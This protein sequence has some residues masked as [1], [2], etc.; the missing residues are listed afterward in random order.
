MHRYTREPHSTYPDVVESI[1]QTLMFP[2]LHS[3]GSN[4]LEWVNDA[5]IVLSAED[6]A[7]TLQPPK[8]PKPSTYTDEPEGQI[9]A[10]S[11]WKVLLLLRRHLDQALRLQYLEIDDP[12]GL[13]T[14]LHVCFDHLQ[15]LFLPL[16]RT[17]WMNLCVLVFPNFVTFNMELY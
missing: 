1:I 3:D 11:K 2:P 7:N 9:P 14:Q 12:T 13:W 6:L 4:F 8:P 15:T 5:R 16:A 17:D 10:I